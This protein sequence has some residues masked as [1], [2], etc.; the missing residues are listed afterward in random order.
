M[1]TAKSALWVA[2]LAF[3]VAAFPLL[4][5]APTVYKQNMTAT[6]FGACGVA[7]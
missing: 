3:A 5:A 7:T 6:S 1:P 4:A 2:E